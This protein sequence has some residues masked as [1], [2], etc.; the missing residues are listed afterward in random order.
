MKLKEQTIFY[1]PSLEEY[2]VPDLFEFRQL[3]EADAYLNKLIFGRQHTLME[4]Q[5]LMDKFRMKY[6]RLSY[7]Q[8]LIDIHECKLWYTYDDSGRYVALLESTSPKVEL[9][10]RL[11]PQNQNAFFIEAQWRRM[12]SYHYSH[13]MDLDSSIDFLAQAIGLSETIGYSKHLSNDIK[14]LAKASYRLG[15]VKQCMAY[16][17]Q[18]LDIVGLG[19][20]ARADALDSYGIC[21]CDLA[22]FEEAIEK[23]NESLDLLGDEDKWAVYQNANSFVYVYCTADE[24]ENAMGWI[25]RLEVLGAEIIAAN[26]EKRLYCTYVLD[27]HRLLYYCKSK[28]YEKAY[29][30]YKTMNYLNDIR[31]GDKLDL[32]ERL[33]P[34]L[35]ALGKF[36][37]VQ[38]VFEQ[39]KSFVQVLYSDKKLAT[40]SRARTEFDQAAALLTFEH[41]HKLLENENRQVKEVED[42]IEQEKEIRLQLEIEKNRVNLKSLSRRIDPQFMFDSLNSVSSFIDGNDPEAANRY[43]ALYSK[44]MRV[45]LV[46]SNQDLVSLEEELDV[47]ELYLELQKLRY[48]P[49]LEY[50]IHRPISLPVF[51]LTLPPMLIQPYIEKAIHDLSQ[52]KQEILPA[53]LMIDFDEHE[54]YLYCKISYRLPDNSDSSSARTPDSLDIAQERIGLINKINRRQI[55][56]KE[57]VIQKN[58]E[59]YKQILLSFPV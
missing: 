55:L 30:H 12:Q 32:Y 6:D 20:T 48:Q 54:Q 8:V 41:N 42:L 34:I 36:D 49:N 18:A 46:Y 29:S 23:L 17:D 50:Q 28:Q 40:L 37:E 58:T 11:N 53:V 16:L 27:L 52:S 31:S 7:M 57:D 44:L 5:S 24:L 4:V 43:L 56:V 3:E 47:L 45:S 14:N 2:R 33:I 13:M 15:D 19:I 9:L 39:Y 21:L 25:E 22:R 51:A 35:A 59:T 26:P 10:I 38:G 1:K